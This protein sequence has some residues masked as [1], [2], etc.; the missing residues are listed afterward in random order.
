MGRTEDGLSPGVPEIVLSFGT[1]TTLLL[2]VRRLLQIKTV[3]AIPAQNSRVQRRFRRCTE[4]Q[5]RK[6][7]ILLTTHKSLTGQL[8]AASG[9]IRAAKLLHALEHLIWRYCVVLDRSKAELIRRSE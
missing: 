9:G 6:V 1:K 5:R 2:S 8:K 7:V 3:P 4:V